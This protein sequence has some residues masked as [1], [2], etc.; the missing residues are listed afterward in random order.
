LIFCTCIFTGIAAA[1]FLSGI[2]IAQFRRGHSLAPHAEPL[3]ESSAAAGSSALSG[4]PALIGSPAHL[5]SPVHLGSTALRDAEHSGNLVAPPRIA[6]LSAAYAGDLT[7]LAQMPA[8]PALIHC[9]RNF[10]SDRRCF[11]HSPHASGHSANRPPET[12]ALQDCARFLPASQCNELYIDVVEIA[13]VNRRVPAA[14]VEGDRDPPPSP[15]CTVS[16]S[17]PWCIEPGTPGDD[18]GPGYLNR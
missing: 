12:V 15:D 16:S 7:A 6:D 10:F 11:E 8:L 13:F 17:E 14:P 9:P 4:S 2:D 1:I 5:G 3:F 18:G